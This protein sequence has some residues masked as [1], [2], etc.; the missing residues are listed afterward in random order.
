MCP[1]IVGVCFDVRFQFI[2]M[3]SHLLEAYACQVGSV[4]LSACFLCFRS[5]AQSRFRA[6]MLSMCLV[7]EMFVNSTIHVSIAVHAFQLEA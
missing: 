2:L 4:L 1:G 7:F 3:S 5:F 6:L